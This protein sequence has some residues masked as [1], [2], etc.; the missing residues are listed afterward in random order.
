M[1]V[2]NAETATDYINTGISMGIVREVI[3]GLVLRDKIMS[4]NPS[5]Y[6]KDE[7]IDNLEAIGVMKRAYFAARGVAWTPL[8]AAPQET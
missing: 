7:I 4:R 8:A 5:R 3:S 2:T 1:T 6:S